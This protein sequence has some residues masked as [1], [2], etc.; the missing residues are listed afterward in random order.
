MQKAHSV[1]NTKLLELPFPDEH[2]L[3][4]LSQLLCF[5]K[6]ISLGL[7]ETTCN[8]KSFIVLP[9]IELA[10]KVRWPLLETIWEFGHVSLYS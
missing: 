7:F 3:Y 10:L 8:Y 5:S 4:K 2:I 9:Q 1:L 6:W